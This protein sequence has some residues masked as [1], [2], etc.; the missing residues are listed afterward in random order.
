MEI[1]Y[2]HVPLFHVIDNFQSRWRSSIINIIAM[3]TWW[4]HVLSTSIRQERV[5][6][7]FPVLSWARTNARSSDLLSVDRCDEQINHPESCIPIFVASRVEVNVVVHNDFE[8]SSEGERRESQFILDLGIVSLVVN[9]EPLSQDSG[10]LFLLGQPGGFSFTSCSFSSFPASRHLNSHCWQMN[11]H[12]RTLSPRDVL[13]SIDSPRRGG[14]VASHRRL[15]PNHRCCKGASRT[16]RWG[17]FLCRRGSR[18][19]RWWLGS[20]AFLLGRGRTFRLV[21]ACCFDMWRAK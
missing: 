13:L 8:F 7:I 16:R 3:M 4:H 2:Q 21:M 5:S 1:I 18:R 6:A 20:I 14:W 19:T 11:N 10:F 17:L 12:V 15:D 9:N